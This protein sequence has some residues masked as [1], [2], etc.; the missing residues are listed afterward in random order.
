MA[1]RLYGIIAVVL[2]LAAMWMAAT[3]INLVSSPVL[4]IIDKLRV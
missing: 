1:E 4:T 2:I 3:I